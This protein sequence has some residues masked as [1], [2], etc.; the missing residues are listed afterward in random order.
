MTTLAWLAIAA[1]GVL[2]ALLA[3]LWCCLVV[4]ARADAR[5]EGR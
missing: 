1:A 3:L 5:E 2:V 4:A